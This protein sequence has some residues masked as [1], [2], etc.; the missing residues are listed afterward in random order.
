MLSGPKMFRGG[1]LN[2]TRQLLGDRRSR[3]S[4]LKLSMSLMFVSVSGA[5]PD[6]AEQVG[7]DDLRIRRGHAVRKLRIGLQRALLQE[8]DRQARAVVDRDDLIVLAVHDQ[9]GDVDR[10]QIVGEVGLRERLDAVVVR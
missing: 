7:V 10:L 8:L 2:V 9:R 4:R 1:W 3:R 5:S 6:E